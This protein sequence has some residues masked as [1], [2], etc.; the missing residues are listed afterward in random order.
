MSKV[1]PAVAIGGPLGPSPRS[2][3]VLSG[4]PTASAHLS[5]PLIYV[6]DLR[7]RY[8]HPRCL[9]QPRTRKCSGTPTVN[10]P[11]WDQFGAGGWRFR[12]RGRSGTQLLGLPP[13][14]LLPGN[15]SPGHQSQRR[16]TPVELLAR[17]GSSARPPTPQRTIEQNQL[18]LQGWSRSTSKFSHASG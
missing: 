9:R 12:R 11:H 18:Y 2:P 14:Q 4:N 8:R 16:G 15:S 17:S 1:D 7:R 13:A 10:P 6:G 3:V 5:T